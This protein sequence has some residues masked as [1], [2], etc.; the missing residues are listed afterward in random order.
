MEYPILNVKPKDRQM[1]DVF[2]GYNHNIRI[3]EN[4]FYDMNNMTSDNFPVLSPRKLRSFYKKDAFEYVSGMIAKDKLCFVVG[5][6]FY[7]G[8]EAVEMDLDTQDQGVDARQLVSM[9]SYIIIVPD[10]KWVN[11]IKKDG[12]YEWGEIEHQVSVDT[13]VTIA[14]FR[15]CDADGVVYTD[16]KVR[17]GIKPTEEDGNLWLDTDTT[18][19]V[20]KRYSKNN[21]TWMIIPETYVKISVGSETTKIGSGFSVGDG[22]EISGITYRSYSN[23]NGLHTVVACGE[24][25]IVINGMPASVDYNDDELEEKGV[26]TITRKMPIMDFVIESN[27][28]LWG[29]RYGNGANGE[30]VNEI[31][32]SKLG[33]FKNWN[34]FQGI[35]T[36]SY[37]ASCGSDGPFTGAI[38]Y[39]GFPIFFKENCMH[40]VYG[41]YPANFRIQ[42]TPCQGVQS[43]SD[44]SLAIVNETLFYKSQD[45]VCAY[46]GSV[47]VE[48][49]EALGNVRYSN[50]AACAH[51]NKYYISMKD[52]SGAFLLFVYDTS[53]NVWHKEDGFPA[54]ML[55]SYEHEIYACCYGH[56]FDKPGFSKFVITLLGSGDGEYEHDDD[57][58]WM[59]ETGSL[60]M[61]LPDMKYI[62]KLLIRMSIEERGDV[63]ICI[64]YDSA[65]EW[66]KVWTSREVTAMRSFGIPVRL[67]RCDHFRIRISGYGYAKIYSITKTIEK[68]SDVS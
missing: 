49:S 25:Y 21:G 57:L 48:V 42:H 37:V 28:R 64:Q 65:G 44:K 27:N 8:D 18:P 67:K 15:L 12:V 33:D 30:F 38:S 45:A 58:Y 36:D 39:K 5:E 66:E 6:K 52:A 17:P 20:L 23:L 62:S 16:D 56:Y 9:G 68:G 54:R 10:N 46:D 59:V 26:F 2:M 43:G 11:T 4:E 53:K 60:G 24:D 40:K 14:Y 50:A 1:V 61:S 31:Y 63:S 19:P 51:G 7:I 41:D 35:S 34:S 55:L 13:N 22:V 47:P 32:A 29:C 3:G